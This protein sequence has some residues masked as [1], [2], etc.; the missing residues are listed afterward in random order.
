MEQFACAV[1]ATGEPA[2]FNDDTRDLPPEWERLLHAL[3]DES[4]A[5]EV[6]VLPLQLHQM[7]SLRPHRCQERGCRAIHSSGRGVV[8]RA[9][10]RGRP[11][12]RRARTAERLGVP[13]R[14]F[15]PIVRRVSRVS[16]AIESRLPLTAAVAAAVVVA[17]VL[18]MIMPADFRVEARGE[19]QPELRRDVFAPA[20]GVVQQVYV[21][22]AQTV[23][24]G[25]LL[26]EMRQTE[27]DF[28]F[29]RVL[30]ELQ[31]LES[32]WKASRRRACPVSV[33]RRRKTGAKIS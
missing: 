30:G 26:L 3:L 18:L 15:F 2:C 19:L 21:E 23:A 12:A 29:A 8:E 17:T 20:D 4:R 32:S 22:H 33:P 14:P 9:A 10:E 1:L 7:K 13:P 11:A 6:A 28:E 5:R 27:L 25:D 31:R 24:A 16:R